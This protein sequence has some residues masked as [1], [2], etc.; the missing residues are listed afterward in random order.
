MLCML[1]LQSFVCEEVVAVLPALLTA[2]PPQ[3]LALVV[4]QTEIAK[5]AAVLL[6]VQL[7]VSQSDRLDSLACCC[8]GLCQGACTASLMHQARPGS[9]NALAVPAVMHV[10]LMAV[11]M[12]PASYMVGTPIE[13]L[14]CMLS[15]QNS[16]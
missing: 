1:G 15:Q 11:Y 8:E 6:N 7:A 9:L 12:G 14:G 13:S 2:R 5:A 4:S 10:L 16:L 3:A